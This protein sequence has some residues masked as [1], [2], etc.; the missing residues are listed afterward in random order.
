MMF[1]LSFGLVVYNHRI[2]G[3]NVIGD[4]DLKCYF[5]F[6]SGYHL[7]ILENKSCLAVLM[8]LGFLQYML[9]SPR[10]TNYYEQFKLI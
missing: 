4:C 8:K 3:F 9:R 1:S 2:H 6:L 5:R 7:F 10:R